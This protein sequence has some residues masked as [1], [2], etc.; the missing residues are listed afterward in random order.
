MAKKYRTVVSS[1]TRV[2]DPAVE[3]ETVRAIDSIFHLT[4]AT[5]NA[6]PALSLP[7]MPHSMAF[8]ISDTPAEDLAGL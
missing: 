4:P 7:G 6:D 8:R 5:E 3:R 2:V 1:C